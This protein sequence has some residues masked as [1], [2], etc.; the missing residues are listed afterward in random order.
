MTANAVIIPFLPSYLICVDSAE[1]GTLNG[2]LYYKYKAEGIPFSGLEELILMVETI[3]DRVNCPQSSIDKRSFRREDSLQIGMAERREELMAMRKLDTNLN[4][5]EKATFILQV[6]FRQN[7]SWQGS[8]QWV[9]EKKTLHFRS[10]LEL[11]K[12]I[13]SACE[14]GY[15]V[16]LQQYENEA[17]IL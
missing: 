4:R 8:V 11:I 5:G 3:M 1:M 10:A 14:Q 12:I 17:E 7:A 2:T 15:A 13:D 9:E 6:K 16:D